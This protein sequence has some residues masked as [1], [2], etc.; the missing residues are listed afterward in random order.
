[1]HVLELN[2][3]LPSHAS[4]LLWLLV[5]YITLRLLL[6]VQSYLIGASL[7][8]PHTY[9]KYS[10]SACIYTMYRENETPCAIPT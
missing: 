8:E 7:S 3:H 6:I 4:W 5:D 10:E 1:M 9:V 2:I